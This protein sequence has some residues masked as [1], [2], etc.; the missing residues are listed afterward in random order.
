M[1]CASV[2]E[3]QMQPFAIIS[4]LG[5]MVNVGVNIKNRFIKVYKIQGIFGILVI[6]SVNVINHVMLA[7]IWIIKIVSVGKNWFI[8]WW[9]NVMKLLKK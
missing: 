6:A 3:D 5:I 7:G 4:N 9:K 1:E 8:N 2:N